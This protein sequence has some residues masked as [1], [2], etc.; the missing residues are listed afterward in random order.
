MMKNGYWKWLGKGIIEL[1][2]DGMFFVKYILV[3]LIL[4]IL[5]FLIIHFFNLPQ[6]LMLLFLMLLAFPFTTFFAIVY[7]TYREYEP[8]N[9]ELR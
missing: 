8:K 6:F 7:L 3:C 1:L 2:S 9:L 5:A 4:V